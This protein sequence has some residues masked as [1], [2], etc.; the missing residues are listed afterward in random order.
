[1]LD[2]LPG[3]VD[4]SPPRDRRIQS[5]LRGRCF[6]ADMAFSRFEFFYSFNVQGDR[7]WVASSR[8]VQR[9]ERKGPPAGLAMPNPEVCHSEDTE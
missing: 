2:N 7:R 6:V 1:M 9:A 4:H 5:V 8:S 3:S